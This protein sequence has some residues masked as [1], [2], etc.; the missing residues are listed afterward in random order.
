MEIDGNDGYL[1]YGL[2]L[3]N[4]G[5]DLPILTIVPD[6]HD[7]VS[8]GDEMQEDLLYRSAIELV[9]DTPVKKARKRSDRDNLERPQGSCSQHFCL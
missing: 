4:I 7:L 9:S 8:E 6:D 1:L 2:E 3:D 5:D